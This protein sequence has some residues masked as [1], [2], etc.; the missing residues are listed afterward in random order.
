MHT[1][2]IYPPSPKPPQTADY[3]DIASLQQRIS[4]CSDALS[5]MAIDLG[6]AKHCLEFSSDMRKRALAR[7]MQPALAG[8]D[9][10]SKAEAEGRASPGYE[11]EI[12]ILDRQHEAAEIVVAQW[13]A[14]RCCWETARSLLSMSKET[15]RQ[16]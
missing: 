15:I 10:V 3:G 7:A 16:L 13:E 5:E 2:S 6:K 9:A 4:E 12:A 11:R 1:D 8:G 14:K